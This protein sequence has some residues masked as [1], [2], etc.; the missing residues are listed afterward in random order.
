MICWTDA[1]LAQWRAEIPAD[2]PDWRRELWESTRAQNCPTFQEARA[3][4]RYDVRQFMAG[5]LRKAPSMPPEWLK[6]KGVVRI[7]KAICEKRREHSALVRM[8]R[9]A[10]S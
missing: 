9:E 5:V 1:Q 8:E 4:I 10:T 7:R 3:A 6:P 2:F